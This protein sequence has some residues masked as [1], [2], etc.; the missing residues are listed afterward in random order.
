M[1]YFA[2]KQPV[3]ESSSTEIIGNFSHVPVWANNQV[4]TDCSGVKSDYTTQDNKVISKLYYKNDQYRPYMQIYADTGNTATWSANYPVKLFWSQQEQESEDIVP[5]P[6]RKIEGKWQIKDTVYPFNYPAF[7]GCELNFILQDRNGN[8]KQC[9]YITGVPVVSGTFNYFINT[10]NTSYGNDLYPNA[11][12]GEGIVDTVCD[13]SF[14][15]D[16]YNATSAAD[17]VNHVEHLTSLGSIQGQYHG[18]YIIIDTPQDIP[19]VIYKYIETIATFIPEKKVVIKSADGK[20]TRTTIKIDY[21]AHGIKI[22]RDTTNPN[23]VICKI[24]TIAP[25]LYFSGSWTPIK[26]A[27][28]EEDLQFVGLANNPNQRKPDYTIGGTGYQDFTFSGD[29]KVL[30]ECWNYPKPQPTG[31]LTLVCYENKAE[32]NKLDKS[33][34]LTV[35]LTM[36]GTLRSE[37][38]ILN[39]VIEFTYT[40][41][42]IPSFN[43]VGIDYFRRYYFVDKMDV[44]RTGLYRLTLSVDELYTYK[45]EILPCKARIVRTCNP[46][47][48]FYEDELQSYEPI[49]SKTILGQDFEPSGKVEFIPTFGADYDFNYAF[50]YCVQLFSSDLQIEPQQHYATTFLNAMQPV[51]MQRAQVKNLCENFKKSNM[52]N[53]NN[54]IDSFFFDAPLDAISS[55]RLYPINL[56]NYFDLQ[57]IQTVQLQLGNLPLN[58]NKGTVKTEGKYMSYT[59]LQNARR[60]YGKI[61]LSAAQTKRL[62]NDTNRTS[63]MILMLPFVGAVNIDKTTLRKV[64]G[65]LSFSIFTSLDL[66]LGNLTYTVYQNV[67]S[68]GREMYSLPVLVETLQI[69]IDIPV[70]KIDFNKQIGI[71]INSL[72]SIL[73]SAI[74]MNPSQIAAASIGAVAQIAESNPLKPNI[75]TAGVNY[76]NNTVQSWLEFTNNKG[77]QQP[78]VIVYYYDS[79]RTSGTSVDYGYRTNQTAPISDCIGPSKVNLVHLEN[80]GSSITKTELENIER[81]LKEGFIA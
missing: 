8:N 24:E 57:N 78:G 11:L 12:Y 60:L 22:N 5:I 36:T 7:C 65:E 32:N 66:V 2:M 21:D 25:G 80:M 6:T 68:D 51:L 9:H 73:G 64:S 79:L 20:T 14:V 30:Y 63:K 69:G 33:K 70:S 17:L 74:T 13:V 71:A 31:N 40:G 46:K 61:K 28:Y 47:F 34:D 53:I 10:E 42:Q 77:L 52:D 58:G 4:Y 55:I 35:K 76:Q 49:P 39:P 19:E 59:A 75:S 54:A 41:N 16:S 50:M 27:E 45:D 23:N 38:D 1:F 44:I 67:D 29:E 18:N 3:D 81:K 48:T 72:S 62:F 37:C 56:D 15:T 26:P 43:Y